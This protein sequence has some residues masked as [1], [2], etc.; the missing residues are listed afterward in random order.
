[1]NTLY[2]LKIYINER[3]IQLRE[4]G[5]LLSH[6]VHFSTEVPVYVDDLGFVWYI[7]ILENQS[8]DTQV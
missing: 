8:K 6:W 1:M 5:L 7:W 3:K 4:L 2:L